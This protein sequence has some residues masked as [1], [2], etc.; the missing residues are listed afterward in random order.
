MKGRLLNMSPRSF[1]IASAILL[2]IASCQA[3]TPDIMRNWEKSEANA[4]DI[5][6]LWDANTEPNL[7]GYKIHYRIGSPG[8]PFDGTE[9]AE[10]DS[11]I[12]IPLSELKNPNN[13]AF[14]MHG[15]SEIA[16]YFFVVTAYGA[17]GF[18]SDYS[19]RVFI[20]PSKS[21]KTR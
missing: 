7:S 15:L 4:P 2:F 12:L 17:N 1:L 14:E 16:T 9:A 11:P 19:N 5:I 13:P 21:N 3:H 10:G 20:T 18:S 6:L 8:P